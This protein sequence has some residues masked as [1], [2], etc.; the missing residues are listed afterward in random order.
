M[1]KSMDSTSLDL[2]WLSMPAGM[3]L[4]LGVTAGGTVHFL[5][6]RALPVAEGLT[7]AITAIIAGSIITAGY[8]SVKGLSIGN[9]WWL[10]AGLTFMANYFLGGME[11]LGKQ[12]RDT[13][14][15]SVVDAIADAYDAIMS[16]FKSKP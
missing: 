3:K 7:A 16:R 15:K 5:R 11:T 6:N 10:G 9:Y 1:R 14:V 12:I 8:C 13:P 4:L 2:F